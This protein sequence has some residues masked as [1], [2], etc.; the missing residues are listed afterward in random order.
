MDTVTRM[1]YGL[2]MTKSNEELVETV[3]GYTSA[4]AAIKS[5]AAAFDECNGAGRMAIGPSGLTATDQ[6]G[7][8]E[9]YTARC[10]NINEAASSQDE[11]YE[12]VSGN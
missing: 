5:W 12:I 9:Y 10:L 8:G 2:Y 1:G 7:S 6:E 3:V 4:V 11:V